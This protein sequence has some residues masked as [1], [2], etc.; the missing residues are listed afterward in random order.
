VA[1]TIHR[2]KIRESPLLAP[3]AHSRF[4]STS[5]TLAEL[6]LASVRV[7]EKPQDFKEKRGKTPSNDEYGW[8]RRLS[9]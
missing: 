5:T 6:M 2:W 4:L 7:T 1:V 9:R 3:H 8:I